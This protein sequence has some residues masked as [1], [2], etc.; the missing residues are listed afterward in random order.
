[1]VNIRETQ[2]GDYKGIS[3]LLTELD[4][5]DSYFTEDRF[6]RMLERNKGYC[7]V[8]EEKGRIIG[9]A[10]A[11]HDGAFRA[12]IR[13]VAVSEDYRRQGIASGLVRKIVDKLAE[14]E[15]PVVFTR[16][17]KHNDQSIELFKS[18]GFDCRDSQYIMDIKTDKT[19]N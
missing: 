11:T 6:V 10:F 8:A 15:I 14:A 9:S 12:Y 16:V 2:E 17:G 4:L 13:K 19:T 5:S 7:Y 3:A 1:M 18:L